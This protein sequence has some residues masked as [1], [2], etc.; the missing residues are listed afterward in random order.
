MHYQTFE[1]LHI[2]L[3][4][5]LV[6]SKLLHTMAKNEHFNY[7]LQRK[8]WAAIALLIS[9]AIIIVPALKFSTAQGSKKEVNI[10]ETDRLAKDLVAIESEINQTLARLEEITN[11]SEKI[12]ESI[13]EQTSKIN[14]L[15]NQLKEKKKVLSQRIRSIY[16]N[17]RINNIDALLSSRDFT[18]FLHRAELTKKVV[19][20]DA[21]LVKT[22]REQKQILSQNL[23][24]LVKTKAKLDSLARELNERKSRL[25]KARSEKEAKLAAAGNKREELERESEQV[26]NKIEEINPP[27]NTNVKHTGKFLIMIATAYSPEEPGLSDTTATGLKAQRGICA[28][29]PSFIP[30]GTRLYVEGYG[31]ALAA[32]TGSAI[33]GNRIDLCFD[34]LEEA[35]SYGMKK[36]KVEILE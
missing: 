28:V 27:D 26:L 14:Y 21:E 15:S 30:L 17:G 23:E 33:K 20:S 9:A 25:E 36:V 13:E 31:Y 2:D 34:T 24:Q 3:P 19:E 1:N 4:V 16:I 12:K 32:D 6:S 8:T 29:D 7:R 35:L 5:L 18:D 10:S 11:N 22:I